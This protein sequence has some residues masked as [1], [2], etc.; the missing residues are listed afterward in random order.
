M[1]YWKP[2]TTETAAAVKATPLDA[3][4]LLPLYPQYSFATTLSSMKEWNLP[5]STGEAGA[6]LA[7]EY[8]RV[9]HPSSIYRSSNRKI[10]HQSLPF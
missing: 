6:P 8:Q 4:V 7:K 1:R 5:I 9:P 2:L 3:L 10:E